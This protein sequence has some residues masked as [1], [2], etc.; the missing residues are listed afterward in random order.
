MIRRDH[1]SVSSC[2]TA[3]RTPSASSSAPMSSASRAVPAIRMVP[4]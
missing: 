4:S 1:S 2:C 3:T